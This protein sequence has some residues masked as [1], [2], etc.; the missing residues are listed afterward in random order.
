MSPACPASKKT[1]HFRPA[2]LESGCWNS[3]LVNVEKIPPGIELETLS[4]VFIARAF[5]PTASKA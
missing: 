4:P 5:G 3:R 2:S 1:T